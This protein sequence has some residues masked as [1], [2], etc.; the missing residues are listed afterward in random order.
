MS[1]NLNNSIEFNPI[2]TTVSVVRRSIVNAEIAN[3]SHLNDKFL[4]FKK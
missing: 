2:Y 1:S 4:N 3:P